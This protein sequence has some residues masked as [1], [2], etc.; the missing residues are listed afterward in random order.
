VADVGDVVRLVGQHELREF[1]GGHQPLVK[2]GVAGVAVRE[3]VVAQKPDV[4]KT[5]DSR[6]EPAWRR[7]LACSEVLLVVEKHDAVDLG[8]LES[9]L[10]EVEAKHRQLLELKPQ[11]NGIPGAGL[12]EPVQRNPQRP[13]LGSVEMVDDD[14]G[15]FRD[16]LR[17]G[18]LPQAVAF[19][20]GSF[21]VDQDRPA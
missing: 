10:D 6:L 19:D 12:A 7:G 5:R 2:R 14:A 8:G 20:D 3:A 21:R 11:R 16:A 13:Q 18:D 15:H 1:A 4:A 9:R 17:P